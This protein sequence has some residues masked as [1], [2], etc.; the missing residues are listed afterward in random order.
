MTMLDSPAIREDN[1]HGGPVPNNYVSDLYMAN[2]RQHDPDQLCL[3]P[4]LGT[5]GPS[6]PLSHPQP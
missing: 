5:P 2:A 3:L 1:W 4:T 6:R